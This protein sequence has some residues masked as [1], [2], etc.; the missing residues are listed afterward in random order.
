MKVRT[1]VRCDRS[2]GGPGRRCMKKMTD[3]SGLAPHDRRMMLTCTFVSRAHELLLP[4]AASHLREM[5]FLQ[6]QQ[7]LHPT[8]RPQNQL[9]TVRLRLRVCACVSELLAKV[10]R[11]LTASNRM[12]ITKVPKTKV[13][14]KQPKTTGWTFPVPN[15]LTF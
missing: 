8:P 11:R 15:Q 3:Q 7:Y 14:L 2:R 9:F 6:R 12:S 13:Y 5:C 10:G 4:L 1:D